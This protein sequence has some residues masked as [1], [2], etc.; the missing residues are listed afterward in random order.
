MTSI[1]TALV[2]GAS[3]FV[4]RHLCDLLRNEGVHVRA[5]SIASESGPWDE[6]FVMDLTG[7]SDLS[8]VLEG[9]DTVFHLAGL[10]HASLSG[11]AARRAYESLNVGATQRLV[12]AAV[13]AG[14]ARIVF[15]SSVKTIGEGGPNACDDTTPPHPT[16]DYGRTKLAAEDIVIDAHREHGL[17]AAAIR[18]V[19]IYGPGVKGNLRDMLDA[20]AA[21]RFPSVPETGNRRSLVDVRD[22][23]SALWLAASCP[24]AA[25][26]RYIVSDGETY[27]T[28]R[29]YSAMAKAAGKQPSGSGWPEG[30][31]ALAAKLGDLGETIL[32][33]DLPYNGERH[34]KLFGSAEFLNGGIVGDL[35][36]APRFTLENAAVDMAQD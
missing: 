3:G 12:D 7:T 6:E 9:V 14:S 25:G 21:G 2:T 18:S 26:K 30:F 20:V 4:G 29:I 11:E 27:S 16:T 34:N 22:V 23:A 5:L 36:F 32:R 24:E 8:P 13:A 19:L 33:R 10:A 1:R 15:M 28:R 31:L 17:H 35:S